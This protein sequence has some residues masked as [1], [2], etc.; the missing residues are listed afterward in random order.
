MPPNT[1]AAR[2][3][4]DL[5]TSYRQTALYL[6]AA[7]GHE[8]VVQLLLEKGADV[9]AKDNDGGTALHKTAGSGH[10]A[11]VRLLL[12]K[13]ADVDA[14]SNDGWTALHWAAESGHEAVVQLLTPLTPDS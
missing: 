10:E 2:V 12:E 9:D 8:A 1:V 7:C 6:M 14:K 3:A 11:V 4:G 13:G 5:Q